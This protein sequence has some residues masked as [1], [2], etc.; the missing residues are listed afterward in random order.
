M[1]IVGI[2]P[3]LAIFFSF[4]IGAV[5]GGMATFLFRRMM[6]NRQLRIAQ[7]KAARITTEARAESKNTINAAKQEAEKIKAAADAEYRERRA[8]LQ[9]QE[10]R[11]SQKTESLEHKL[12][13]V[14]QRERNLTN[15]EKEMESIRTHLEEVRDKQLKAA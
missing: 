10:N 3:I 5:F 7:R 6:L 15:K 4:V 9:R 14:E 8:E 1:G 12:E 11:L 13:G 2:E